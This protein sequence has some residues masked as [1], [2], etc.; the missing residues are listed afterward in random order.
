MS[1]TAEGGLMFDTETSSPYARPMEAIEPG[2]FCL[3]EGYT[4]K[5]QRDVRHEEGLV[6]LSCDTCKEQV[7]LTNCCLIDIQGDLHLRQGTL[8]QSLLGSWS[9]QGGVSWPVHSHGGS[10]R[11]KW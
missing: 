11:P 4:A 1:L 8:R 7:S 6:A 5:G 3:I 2:Q 10:R 9:Y